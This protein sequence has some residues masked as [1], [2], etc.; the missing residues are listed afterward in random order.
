MRIRVKETLVLRKLN[1]L[2]NIIIIIMARG[3]R[4]RET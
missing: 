3:M 1:T 4:R 2:K